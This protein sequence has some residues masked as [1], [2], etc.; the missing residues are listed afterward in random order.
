MIE[1][2]LLLIITY[3]IIELSLEFITQIFKLINKI[4]KMFEILE[5]VI[6]SIIIIFIIFFYL[7]VSGII[8]MISKL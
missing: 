7:Y 2:I 4:S 5:I 3:G 8:N 1:K 6:K